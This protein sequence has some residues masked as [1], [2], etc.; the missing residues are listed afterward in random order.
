MSLFCYSD[1]FPVVVPTYIAYFF[2]IQKHIHYASCCGFIALKILPLLFGIM[3]WLKMIKIQHAY[4]FSYLHFTINV[5]QYSY[6]FMFNTTFTYFTEFSVCR[7][8]LFCTV[9]H[10]SPYSRCE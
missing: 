2:T 7:P 9:T 6:I 4:H 8:L 3:P 10:L 1:L 5:I